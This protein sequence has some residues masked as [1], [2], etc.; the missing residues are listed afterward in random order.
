MYKIVLPRTGLLNSCNELLNQF[1]IPD[2]CNG[3]IVDF[4]N[5]VFYEISSVVML[6]AKLHVLVIKGLPV[7]IEIR[8]TST[9]FKYMQ[10]M[11]F[12][13]LC[14][15]HVN[16]S[17]SRHDP[18]GRFVDIK[19]IG[20]NHRID[21]GK[22][23]E[24]VADC[25]APDQKDLVDPEQTGGYDGIS[26]S[27]SELINNVIQHSNSY[28]FLG[29]QHYPKSDLTQIVVADIGIGIRQSFIES[30]SPHARQVETDR[31]AIELA[32]KAEVSS[33][34]HGIYAVGGAENAGVGL[35][36]LKDVALSSGGSFLVVSGDSCFKDDKWL[37]L[38]NSYQG[39]LVACSFK[40][41]NLDDFNQLLE[42]A[43]IKNGLTIEDV[44]IFSGMFEQ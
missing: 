4:T 29:A 39:T 3:I 13:K 19:A 5:V 31:L 1:D 12:F 36:L 35:S 42:N 17:F 21:T 23:S 10:R 28:G 9:P 22:L 43:K 27:V 24:E 30:G 26:Y 44:S 33:K 40:R 34:S 14:G 32:L 6:L 16:E 2:G 18:A 7:N 25:I 38:K 15:I 11:N 8:D 20:K 41:S 37:T